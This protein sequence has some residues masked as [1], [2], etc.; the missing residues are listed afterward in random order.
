MFHST[1]GFCP[2]RYPDDL[3]RHGQL[4]IETN[5]DAWREER[6]EEGTHY[7]TFLLHK[8][9]FLG[10]AESVSILRF[11][12]AI[13]SAR[14]AIG[15]LRNV[16]ELEQLRRR[17][18]LGDIV[19]EAEMNEAEIRRLRSRDRLASAEGKSG[20]GVDELIAE[21]LRAVDAAVEAMF[22]KRQ[23]I[24][25]LKQDPRFLKLPKREQKAVL[26]QVR[27]RLDAGEISARREMHDS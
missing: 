11:S 27:D 20:S 14:V 19:H 25:D 7:Y 26:K 9:G 6:P 3:N 23:K 5:G 21:E 4:I 16:E 18:E 15:R 8:R 1:T 24:R 13:P 12:E 22:A 2:E 17:H 10:L